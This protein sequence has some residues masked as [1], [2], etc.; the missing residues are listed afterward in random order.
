VC[1]GTAPSTTLAQKVASKNLPV[2]GLYSTRDNLVPATWGTNWISWIDKYNT[3]YASKTKLTI[4]TDADH[5]GTW[6]RAFNP[7]TKVDG[8]NIYQWMLL[9]TRGTTSTAPP[10]PTSGNTA[11]IAVA[12]PDQSVPAAWNYLRLNGYG[13]KDPDGWLTSIRWSQVSGPKILTLASPTSGNTLV[14]G[15]IPGTYVFKVTVIDNKGAVATDQATIYITGTTSG[16]T[17]APPPP[18][19]SVP[20]P[21]NAING[22]IPPTA[23]GGP[24]QTVPISWNY[25]RLNGFASYD[26]DGWVTGIRWMQV[27]GPNRVTIVSPSSANTLVRGMIAGRYVFRVAVTDNRGT[28]SYD[29]VTV[30]FTNN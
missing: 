25:L 10:P 5:N 29:D 27:T 19:S 16:G 8:Y 6:M 9:Y 3:A 21:S 30:T 26:K 2:W 7:T 28:I 18:S 12:G 20:G 4:W 1:G 13:S 14:R 17:T 23:V 22:N 24:D 11:P 15:M